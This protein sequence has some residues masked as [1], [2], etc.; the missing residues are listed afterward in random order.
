M[1]APLA[2]SEWDADYAGH[3]R[4]SVVVALDRYEPGK[5]VE[6]SVSYDRGAL[7]PKLG[8]TSCTPTLLV[9]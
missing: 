7:I 3:V 1:L 6:V 5:F 9:D 8:L 2:S 4:N